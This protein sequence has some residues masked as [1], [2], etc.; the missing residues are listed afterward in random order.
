MPLTRPT[1]SALFN[2]QKTSESKITGWVCSVHARSPAE[3][4]AVEVAG[5]A[6]RQEPVRD[7][8]PEGLHRP[9]VVHEHLTAA[10]V[11]TISV[12]TGKV[13]GARSAEVE[14]GEG[15]VC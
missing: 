8:V 4:V 3:L 11:M 12:M 7:L 14:R 6:E 5:A 10:S 9:V 15:G 1:N 13:A 2:N